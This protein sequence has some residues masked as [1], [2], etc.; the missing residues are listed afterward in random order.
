MHTSLTRRRR[1]AISDI[2]VVPYIDVMLVLLVI[3]MVV[4][5]MVNPGVVD[6]PTVGA[7]AVQQQPPLVITIYADQS[8]TAKVHSTSENFERK[9]TNNTLIDL[10]RQRQQS[11]PDE[12][13]VIAADK[14]V[15]YNAVMSIMAQLKQLGVKRV[16]L[17]V[18]SE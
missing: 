7:T 11:V 3:F 16:G 5:P 14:S 13:V 17:L 15:S 8:L 12:P 1:K 9:L 2:N 10:I 18:K 6:L 4:A